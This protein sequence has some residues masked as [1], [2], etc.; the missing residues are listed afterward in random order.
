[1]TIRPPLLATPL[2]D[3][4]APPSSR[5]RIGA[6]VNNRLDDA[7]EQG[8]RGLSESE[9]SKAG[10]FYRQRLEIGL[11]TL[12]KLRAQ[13]WEGVHSR[14]LRSFAEMAFQ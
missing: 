4:H 12:E 9:T 7:A 5:W 8:R 13:E 11:K 2:F 14:T 3:C 10:E 1:M 6:H